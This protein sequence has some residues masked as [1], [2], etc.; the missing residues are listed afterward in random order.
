M[1]GVIAAISS[2]LGP[3]SVAVDRVN[4]IATAESVVIPN[5]KIVRN[6]NTVPMPT[7]M[8]VIP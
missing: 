5:T 7:S 3:S 6:A 1:A 8:S 4:R 2:S